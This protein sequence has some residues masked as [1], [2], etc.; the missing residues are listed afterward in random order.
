MGA[1]AGPSDYETTMEQGLRKPTK[2][3]G[4]QKPK[5]VMTRLCLL[6]W[7]VKGRME[8]DPWL[9]P[10]ASMELSGAAAAAAATVVV[11]AAGPA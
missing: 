3:T 5:L 2:A 6:L 7:R 8:T 9:G 1:A 10:E 11:V 4:H